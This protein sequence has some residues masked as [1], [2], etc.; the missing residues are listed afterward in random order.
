[1]T[2]TSVFE[3]IQSPV[4]AMTLLN[5]MGDTTYVWE[6]ADDEKWLAVI[7][8][9]MKEGWV[10]FVVE[11][12]FWDLQAP[13]LTELKRA[14]DALK[15]RTVLVKDPDVEE[16]LEAGHGVAVKTPDAKVSA[17]RK[18]KTA[19]DTVGEETVATR[20]MKGG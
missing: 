14:R 7:E 2:D 10:F 8:K 1:M 19:E 16:L 4:R 9:K 20:A 12:R 5:D 13:K 15:T 3:R 18:A 6:E 17:R 11:R